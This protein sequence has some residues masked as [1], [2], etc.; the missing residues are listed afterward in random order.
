MNYPGQATSLGLTRLTTPTTLHQAAVTQLREAIIVGA[1][2]PGTLLKDAEVAKQLGLSATPVREALLQLAS[3]G[4]VEIEAN[5]LK[6]VTPIDHQAMVELIQ[7]QIELW[8]LGYAWGGPRIGAAE[9]ARLTEANIAHHRAVSRGDVRART[10]A[11]H[12]FH[13]VLMQASCNR[14]LVRVAVDRLPLL[15]RYVLLCVPDLGAEDMLR[16]HEAMHAALKR[17]DVAAAIATFRTASGVLRAAAE[18]LRDAVRSGP[19]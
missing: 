7:I 8:A 10:L 6:R 11:A 9:L 15:Q 5:R 18:S 12:A 3:E 4:L 16:H 17:G 19:Q 2:P 13:L 1:L 14:E